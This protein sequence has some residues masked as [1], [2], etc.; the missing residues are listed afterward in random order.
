[1]RLTPPGAN[2]LVLTHSPDL[3]LRI[4][5]AILKRGDFGFVGLIGSRTKRARF[6]SRLTQRGLPEPVV[7]RITCPIGLPGIERKEPLVIAVAAVAQLLYGQ[8]TPTR[9]EGCR[10]PLTV[11]APMAAF[12]PPALIPRPA[13]RQWGDRGYRTGPWASAL[14]SSGGG[15][16]RSARQS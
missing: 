13:P 7:Q 4:C 12:G 2:H 8:S 1:M 16:R 6:G 11:G 3:G 10:C 15:R 9:G 5:E 14:P